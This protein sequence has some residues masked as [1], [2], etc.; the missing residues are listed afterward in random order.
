MAANGWAMGALSAPCRCAGGSS[1]SKRWSLAVR[2]QRVRAPRCIPRQPHKRGV[3][4][5]PSRCPSMFYRQVDERGYPRSGSTIR[6]LA[7][8]GLAAANGLGP[9]MPA[10]GDPQERSRFCRIPSRGC[11]HSRSR[12]R[13]RARCC[14]SRPHLSGCE[15]HRDRRQ[16]SQLALRSRA[17]CCGGGTEYPICAIGSP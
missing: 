1:N 11:R 10:Q 15:S 6:T 14:R 17:M 12:V 9:R 16:R 4:S 7:L 3:P 2:R 5:Y 8:S 13:Y